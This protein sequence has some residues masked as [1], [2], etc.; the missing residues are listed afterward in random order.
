MT[1]LSLALA[2]S[3]L[4]GCATSHY[5]GLARDHV[6]V[7][8]GVLRVAPEL[9]SVPNT[10][11]TEDRDNTGA[12]L[13]TEESVVG[14]RKVVTGFTLNRGDT[15]ID[16]QDFYELARDR[17]GLDAVARA[18]TRDADE[19]RRYRADDRRD[20]R[21]DRIADCRGPRCRTVRRRPVVPVVSARPRA[22][23]VRT[24]PFRQQGLAGRS[25]VRRARPCPRTE[26][27]RAPQNALAVDRA[28]A[29][30]ALGLVR[31]L[32]AMRQS[33]VVRELADVRV[34]PAG[35][36]VVVFV[37]RLADPPRALGLRL[38]FRLVEARASTAAV[39]ARPPRRR[40]QLS[41]LLRRRGAWAER[42][43][44]RHLVCEVVLFV[45]GRA[46]V[47]RRLRGGPGARAGTVRRCAAVAGT[48]QQG[49]EERD[50]SCGQHGLG[51]P[52]RSS[53]C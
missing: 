16:E 39:T 33:L 44:D 38:R 18:G 22:R 43:A 46:A 51:R 12:L 14:Y 13:G 45:R 19:P 4:A 27:H 9:P 25:R 30:G 49:H 17:D 53:P 11:V 10:R 50:R 31:A 6:T 29:R 7:P 40:L 42:C 41:R 52:G 23:A 35:S 37:A 24:T 36:A 15:T 32:L 2:I 8:V 5:A 26:S 21:R 34:A 3:T 20:R 47:G 28:I 1:T 48:S